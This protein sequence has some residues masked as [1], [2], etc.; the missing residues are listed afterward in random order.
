LSQRYQRRGRKQK[1][2]SGYEKNNKNGRNQG[3]DF[4]E[5]CAAFLL[6]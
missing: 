4:S 1:N 3:R 5:N 2:A 6:F